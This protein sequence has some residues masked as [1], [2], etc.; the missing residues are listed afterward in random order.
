[1]QT[2]KSSSRFEIS[3]YRKNIVHHNIE[4][5]HKGEEDEEEKVDSKI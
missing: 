1:M 3:K 2:A 4:S 5:D